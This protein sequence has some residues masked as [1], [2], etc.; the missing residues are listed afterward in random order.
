MLDIAYAAT[1]VDMIKLLFVKN[2][3]DMPLYHV[4]KL[5]Q[6]TFVKK[7]GSPQKNF[8]KNFS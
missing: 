5:M 3:F 2:Q 4:K 7:G 8:K 6:M 1:C